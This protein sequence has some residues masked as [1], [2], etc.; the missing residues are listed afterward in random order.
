M[1]HPL[2]IRTRLAGQL[3]PSL[4]DAC[5]HNDLE[6]V[7]LLTTEFTSQKYAA[8]L[9]TAAL[10]EAKEVAA[11]CLRDRPTRNGVTDHALWW[12]LDDNELDVAYIWLVESGFVNVNH[13]IDRTG[14]MLGILAGESKD[15]RYD[16]VRYMLEKG[17][18]P[19]ENVECYGG[20]SALA[21]AAGHSDSRMVG[22]LLDHGAHINGRAALSYA[23]RC[24]NEE[25]VRP[26]LTRGA[27]V[28]EIVPLSAFTRNRGSMGSALH[29]AVEFGHLALV[30]TLLDAGA[31]VALKDGR[32][33]TAAD[34]AAQKGLHT[35]VQAK[36]LSPSTMPDSN[37]QED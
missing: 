35:G 36:L 25:N 29:K 4:Y 9:V 17:A 27:D 34:I 8:V 3:G 5:I 21:T 10:G 14:S 6:V 1:V 16:L 28:N 31:D 24:G 30:D 13:G 23:A 22:L 11:Y 18:I 12:I 20:A 19:N 7:Q 15:K 26:L 32:G 2:N 37:G 33:R